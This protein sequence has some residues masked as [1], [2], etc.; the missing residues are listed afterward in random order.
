MNTAAFLQRNGIGDGPVLLVTSAIHMPRSVAVFRAA[1][2]NVIPAPTDITVL[3][4]RYDGLFGWLPAIGALGAT[5]RAVHEYIGL[6][7]YWI[8]GW[9]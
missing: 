9:L 3:D 6:C 4:T 2:V 7:V 1:G 5:S 8:R